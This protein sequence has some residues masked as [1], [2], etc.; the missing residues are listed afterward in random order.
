M[1]LRGLH[2][3]RRLLTL[4]AVLSQSCSSALAD[5]FTEK[6][7]FKD[8]VFDDG[9]SRGVPA[10]DDVVLE[11]E[12]AGRPAPTVYWEHDGV[13][14]SPASYSSADRSSRTSAHREQVQPME[15]G[16]TKA[17]LYIDCA[18]QSDAGRYTCVAETS[19]KRIST[20]TNIEVEPSAS[21]ASVH[22]INRGRRQAAHVDMWTTMM[23]DFEGANS[24]LFCR[25]E[26]NPPPAITWFDPEDH[27]ITSSGS[28]NQY[29]ITENGDLVIRD[30]TWSKN[31]GLYKCY[32][33]NVHGSDRVETFLYPT[34]L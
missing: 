27:H 6:L 34:T 11:C 22:C 31:M 1:T 15:L 4:I 24:V 20:T 33:Q 17:R 14:L 18:Q 3:Q 32:A 16:S 23:L 10:G 19:T 8:H 30:I 13:R 9:S 25:A 2:V 5:P 29:L 26:G 21:D 7:F 28:H 12:A